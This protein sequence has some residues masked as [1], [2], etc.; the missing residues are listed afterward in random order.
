MKSKRTKTRET[1]IKNVLKNVKLEVDSA[2]FTFHLSPFTVFLFTF[3]MLW[4]GAVANATTIV[5]TKHNLSVSGPGDIKST[6]ETRICVFCHTPHNAT[7]Q[8]PLWNKSITGVTYTLYSSTTLTATGQIRQPDGPTRLCLSCHDGTVALGAVLEPSSTIPM[9]YTSIPSS[10]PSYIGTFLQ[11]DHPVSFLYGASVS[12]PEIYPT[13]PPGLLFYNNSSVDCSTCH[14]PHEDV[15]QSPDTNGVLTGKFL[16]VN[17]SY[18]ALCT[19]C[20]NIDGWGND[21]HSTATDTIAAVCNGCLPVP[22]RTWPTWTTV[23]AWGCENCHTMH[24]SGSTSWL[25]Y[26]GTAE[27]ICFPCH[28]ASGPQYTSP[29]H[30]AHMPQNEMSVS[31]SIQ[32][33][34]PAAHAGEGATCFSCHDSP[35]ISYSRFNGAHDYQS[36]TYALNVQPA[37]GAA[38]KNIYA[39]YQ[40]ISRHSVEQPGTIHGRKEAQR[41]ITRQAACTDCHDSHSLSGRTATAPNASAM[42]GKVSG[43]DING[44]S[45]KPVKFEYEVCFKCHSDSSPLIPFSAGFPRPRVINSTNA[46]QQFNTLNASYHPVAGIGK[47]TSFVPSIAN[48]Q[49]VAGIMTS[50]SIIYCMDCHES[51]DSSGIPG[52]GYSGPRGPHGSQY[53]P[54]LREEYLTADN[55]PESYANYALCYRCHDRVTVLNQVGGS[56]SWTKHYDHIVTD[57]TP[58]SACHDPHG[59]YDPSDG[60]LTG[61]HSRLINFDTSIAQ[62]VA[63]N[64]VPMFNSSMAG[65]GSCTL[66]CHN[67]THICSKYP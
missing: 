2:P 24:N 25:L 53:A 46:R 55:T 49:Y 36:T 43:V 3:F 18:S 65:S 47:N 13:P 58:C 29:Y 66:V 44:V 21:S 59:I 11:Y 38:K 35:S 15:Y 45:L 8:T 14:D 7:P 62:P 63:P 50:S 17:N 57:N 16:A 27:D 28:G 67:H 4:V 30:A 5:N 9:T 10:R 40:K 61:S 22:P 37:P 54:L 51:D 19:M 32:D 60:M 52:A 34:R 56:G 42:L 26:Y 20:H 48:S 41:L 64:T 33:S 1:D 39:E 6:S 23:A 31:A 12:N